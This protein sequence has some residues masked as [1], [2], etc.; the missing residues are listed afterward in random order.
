[1]KTRVASY[2][3]ILFIGCCVAFSQ[4]YQG[5][6]QG[7]VTDS[8]GAFLPD[9]RITVVDTGTNVTR[10]LLTN[11]AGEY[12]APNLEPGTYTVVAQRTGFKESRTTVVLEVG[13]TIR[14]DLA[15]QPGAVSETVQVTAEQTLVDATDSTLNG[16]LSNKAINELPLQGRDFQNLLPLHPGVQRT[17]GG[18]F[19]SITSNGNRPDENNFY[20]D[21]ANDNDVYYGESVV[22]EAGIQGTPASFMPLDAIQ[23]FNTQESPSAEYGEKPGVVMNLGLKSGT[24]DI[25]GTAYY[26]NRNSYYDARNYFNPYPAPPSALNMHQFGTSIGGPIKKD[27]WFYFINYEGIRDRVGN[28]GVYDSP[29]TVSLAQKM[30]G[31]AN[32]DGSPNSASYSLPDAIAY[33]TQGYYAAY[34][35]VPCTP[36]P[37]SLHIAQ[38][39]QPNP[40]FSLKQ[41]DPAA[42]NF[43]WNNTNRGD[44]LVAKT[45]YHLNDHHSFA[46]RYFYGNSD[47][48][49]AD[50]IALGPQWLSTTS[51]VTQIFGANWT[52]DPTSA[53]VNEVRFS[54]N[55]FNEGIFP[56]DHN[57]NPLTYGL[58]TGVTN[59]LLFGFPRINPGSDN[60]D[61]MGGNSGWPLRTTPS[62]TYNW[63]DTASYTS[64]RHNLRFGG[65]FMYGDVQYDRATEGRGRVDFGDLTDFVAGN[66]RRWEWLYGDPA[67]NVSMK[68]LGL[69]AQDGYRAT[70]RL[71]LNFGLRYDIT[72]PI[73]D[74]RNLLA[75]YVPTLPNGSPGGIVQVG[76]G[77]SSPYPTRYNNISPR[78]GFAQDLRGNGKTILRA[79]FGIIFTQPSMRTFMF[80]GGGLNLNPSGIPY[81]DQY[82]H[83][84][85]PNGSINSFLVVSNNTDPTQGGVNWGAQPGQI[86]PASAGQSC[87]VGN[88]CSVFATAQH[89]RTPYVENWNLNLQQA[90]SQ[91]AMLQVAYVGNHG[92]NLYSII[93][94]NQVN[95]FAPAEND[96]NSPLFDNCDHCESYGRPL[97]TNC[98]AKAIGGQNTGGPC[99]PY[100]SFLTLLGNQSNS[101]Y[102]SLQVTFTQR[103]SHG[104]YLLAG[105][106]YAHAIDT[107]TSNT[108]S[109]PQNSLDYAAERGNGDYDIRHRL[110]IALAYDLPSRK[111]PL[112]LL[113]GWQ[114]TTLATLQSGEP[115]TLGDYGDDVSLTGEYNDRWNMTGSPKDVHWSPTNPIPFIPATEFTADTNGHVTGGLTPDAQRCYLA[116]IQAGGQAAADQ[117]NGNPN[118]ENTYGF[119]SL[120]SPGCFVSGSAV[121][122]PPAPG[123][124]GNMGRNIFV[125]PGFREW[126]FSL[127]KMW[128]FNERWKMQLRGEVF[129]LLN[130]PN[131][132]VFSMNTDVSVP[133]AVGTAIFTPDLGSASNPV[134][135]TGGSRHIQIGAKIIW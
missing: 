131:F 49:E 104:L 129:N 114:L 77:I 23:E 32:S 84:I 88:Q 35:G 72:F 92:V 108:S 48:V 68:S 89:L 99:F 31:I 61:Y 12:A 53:W 106:T 112:Q 75:N 22:N 110:T 93:D 126:D 6:I 103:Y 133:T 15:L 62:A 82:G 74:S 2:V 16:V 34:N 91:S 105:Y 21:G 51:P 42:I 96:P 63:S 60:F 90:L 76:R 50:T 135:G 38:Y 65:Q 102:N 36:N 10:S 98:Q 107:A 20:I 117:L 69:F 8:S 83:T 79:G 130:H 9:A 118:F 95:P 44:N 85:Q 124:F 45:D 56:V 25:H 115:Y 116:A 43:D 87:S 59:P 94:A 27:K 52:W 127:S 26:F 55:K 46:V 57:V 4:T 17:P 123:N 5:K 19:Q 54:F 18:G 41:S 47:L 11:A 7:A 33:C 14:V 97:V 1:M 29:V 132:D 109:G 122:T 39:L 64:G 119:S 101:I 121:I 80:S 30:G 86:F 66:P 40:G 113:E 3:L 24:N 78:I 67:R 100:I 128:K 111:S 134:L 71:T 58:D 81:V 13:R 125:G 70:Q 28:P 73:T 120:F 37:L